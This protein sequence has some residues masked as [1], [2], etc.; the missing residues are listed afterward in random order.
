MNTLE[1][2]KYGVNGLFAT[3]IHYTV[4]S[5]NLQ[6]LHFPSVGLANLFASVCGIIT[7]FIGNRCFVFEARAKQSW[8]NQ[9]FKFTILYSIIATMQ[10]ISLWIWTDQYG[11]DYRV[12]FLLATTVQI[13]ISYLGNRFVVFQK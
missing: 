2:I 13:F 5:F 12:G 7:S 3:C 9:L 4:L 1:I 11:F 6:V 10:G 8:L